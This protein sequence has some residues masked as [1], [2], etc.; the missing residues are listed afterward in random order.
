MPSLPYL[1]DN[2]TQLSGTYTTSTAALDNFATSNYVS[3]NYLPLKGAVLNDRINLIIPTAGTCKLTLTGQPFQAAGTYS[4]EGIAFILAANNN[5]WIG[6]TNA[7]AVNT[8]NRVV[9]ISPL[10]NIDCLTT[11]GG[12][13][14]PLTLQGSIVAYSNGI[15][16][17]TSTIGTYNVILMA[18]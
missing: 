11:N 7:L 2:S 8:T 15:G 13:G 5:L 1:T 18:H 4:Q 16:I 3:S 9:R 6:G 14:N 10:G 12:Y 17:G